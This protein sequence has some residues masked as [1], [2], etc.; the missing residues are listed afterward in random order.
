VSAKEIDYAIAFTTMS[1]LWAPPEFGGDL[2]AAML[3]RAKEYHRQSDLFWHG[4]CKSCSWEPV[5]LE[6]VGLIVVRCCHLLC[7]STE[8]FGLLY[9][10]SA[11]I[12]NSFHVLAE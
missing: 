9:F 5:F 8:S 2:Q 3:Q 11:L 6:A 1:L 10:V 7:L 12:I 4:G